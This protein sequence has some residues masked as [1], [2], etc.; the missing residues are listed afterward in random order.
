MLKFL[1]AGA[2][3]VLFSASARAALP[4]LKISPVCTG[5]V[6]NCADSARPGARDGVLLETR[7][8]FNR[9]GRKYDLASKTI[10]D[11][12]A[13]RWVRAID[14]KNGLVVYAYAQ[15]I[16]RDAVKVTLR[17]MDTASGKEQLIANP[18]VTTGFGMRYFATQ[19]GENAEGFKIDVTPNR[20]RYEPN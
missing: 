19:D 20:I 13:G 12:K 18:I 3:L 16:D 7:V 6:E 2:T 15:L 17:V 10:F 5:V 9:D 11:L 4:L 8:H 14:S 1:I